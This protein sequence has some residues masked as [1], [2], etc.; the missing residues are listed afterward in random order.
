[1]IAARGVMVV[2]R[3]VMIGRD[4]V[5][6]VETC[7]MAVDPGAPGTLFCVMN[8]DPCSLLRPARRPA[9]VRGPDASPSEP[10]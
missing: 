2:D 1:M 4:R 9:M 7:V 6:V 10:S 3:R 5:M 8:D